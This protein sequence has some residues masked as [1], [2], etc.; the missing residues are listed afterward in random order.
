[1]ISYLPLSHSAGLMGDVINPLIVG[2][3]CYYA[4]PDAF[5]GSLLQTLLWA[6]PTAFGSVPRIWE[7]FEEKIKETAAKNGF[8]A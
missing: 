2:N 3:T 4:R 6:R 8:L 1:M 5:S 7:K